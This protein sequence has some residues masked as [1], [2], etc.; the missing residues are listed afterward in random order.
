M[1]NKG[2]N[3]RDFLRD[4][5]IGA[6]GLV[7]G[8]SSISKAKA[9]RKDSKDKS[10]TRN[11]KPDMEYRRLGRTG[12]YISAVTLG[13]HWKRVG[14][15]KQDINE[16]R[17]E[18]IERCIE[19]GI[20]YIDACTDI[21]AIAN[22]KALSKKREKVYLGVSHTEHEPR[23]DAYRTSRK[24][25]QSLDEMLKD[26]KLDHADIWRITCLELGRMHSFNT[27]C[28]IVEALEKAK[29]QGKA[30]FIGISSHD[31]RWLKFMV[32]YFPQLEV[33][34]FPFTARSRVKPGDSIFDAVKKNDIGCLGI[35]PFANASIFKGTSAPDDPQAEEDDRRARMAIRK[36]LQNPLIIPMAGMISTHQ[37]DNVVKAAKESRKLNTK[38]SAELQELMENTF[39]NLPENYQWLRQ[40]DYV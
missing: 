12:L 30:R 38:E 10:K 34:L 29:K 18:V 22:N 24:L 23:N 33:V 9:S 13:G 32:E 15:M 3:R 20:N 27:S 4:T 37:V 7:T 5:A 25:L 1:T 39:A 36:I 14:V 31:R 35:K 6:A 17:K 21:E 40:W 28:E 11:Y 16:N 8:I 26:S 19:H 2:I